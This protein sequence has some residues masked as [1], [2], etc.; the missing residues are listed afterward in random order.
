MLYKATPELCQ[1]VHWQREQAELN[2][3]PTHLT[4]LLNLSSAQFPS[5]RCFLVRKMQPSQPYLVS[6]PSQLT[7]HTITTVPVT[8]LNALFSLI[9]VRNLICLHSEVILIIITSYYK[10]PFLCLSWGVYFIP[11]SFSAAQQNRSLRT[12]EN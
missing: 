3:L 1:R 11:T 4:V 7:F 2:W 12:T 5:F 8:A 10:L 9:P 6:P